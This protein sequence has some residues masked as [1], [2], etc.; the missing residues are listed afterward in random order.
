MSLRGR[1]VGRQTFVL[2]EQCIPGVRARARAARTTELAELRSHESAAFLI[3]T[4][5]QWTAARARLQP[6]PRRIDGMARER[7]T[8]LGALLDDEPVGRFD[9]DAMRLEGRSQV[10]F[11]EWRVRHPLPAQGDAHVHIV[12]NTLLVLQCPQ[13][14]AVPKVR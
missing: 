1:S 9:S 5:V 8:K 12:Q 3:D 13:D 4:I 14:A 6:I 10:G 11:Q 7:A 2:C